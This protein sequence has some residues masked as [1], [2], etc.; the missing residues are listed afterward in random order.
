MNL[1][2]RRV[3]TGHDANGKAIV[4]SDAVM[5][6][7]TSRRP[8]QEGCVV[9]AT[10]TVPANNLDPV[11]G[12]TLTTGVTMKNGAVFR[13]VRYEAGMVGAMHRTTTLD[14]GIVLSGAVS[15]V[16]DD[17]VEVELRAGDVIVQRG[18][19]HNWINRGGEACT[20]AF[21]LVDAAPIFENA[22]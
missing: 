7:V 18:T 3:V 14:Y 6:N 22:H 16:L 21:V 1:R 9:W 5:D 2:V 12:A 13:V 15:M 11:D 20:I 10:D 19:I 8:G 4:A 17:G